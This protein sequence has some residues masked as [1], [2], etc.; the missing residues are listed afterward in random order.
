MEKIQNICKLVF[1][2]QAR[3][4]IF[5]NMDLVPGSR[6]GGTLYPGLGEPGRYKLTCPK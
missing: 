6:E 1:K 2:I 3:A 4:A 5:Q